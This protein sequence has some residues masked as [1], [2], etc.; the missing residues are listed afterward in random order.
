M[1]RDR[2]NILVATASEVQHHQM[3]VM[4]LFNDKQERLYRGFLS[5]LLHNRNSK[6]QAESTYA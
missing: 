3:I 5:K 6:V 1:I 4:L 2:E